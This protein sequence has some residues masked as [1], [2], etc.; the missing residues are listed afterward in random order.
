MIEEM[1]KEKMGK[2]PKI[3]EKKTK[4]KSKNAELIDAIGDKNVAR[5]RKEIDNEIILLV[6]ENPNKMK[7]IDILS[8]EEH[9]LNQ[10][11][12]KQ[13]KSVIPY[14]DFARDIIRKKVKK[15]AN[16]RY[17][18]NLWWWYVQECKLKCDKIAPNNQNKDTHQSSRIFVKKQDIVDSPLFD[19]EDNN[20]RS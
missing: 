15:I 18:I 10:V 9:I 16:K 12:K 3:R 17:D 1:I 2:W 7:H 6:V 20:W 11:Y 19:P 5:F 8:L 14:E 13:F 4:F